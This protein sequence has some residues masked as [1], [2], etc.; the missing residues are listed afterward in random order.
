MFPARTPGVALLILRLCIA[1]LVALSIATFGAD[2]PVFIR[3]ACAAIVLVLLCL[4]LFTPIACL[5]S[6]LLQAI[7]LRVSDVSSVVEASVHVAMTVSLFLLG[8]GAYSIDAR[9]YGRRLI[10]PRSY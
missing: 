1:G 2:L 10:M 7:S 3:F 6:L 5:V 8:P 4:G 9:R